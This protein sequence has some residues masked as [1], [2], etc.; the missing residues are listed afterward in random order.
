MSSI[1]VS[2]E[3]QVLV[4]GESVKFKLT[5]ARLHKLEHETQHRPLTNNTNYKYKDG[6]Q[7]CS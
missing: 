6:N 3:G 5:G 7:S 2:V 4:Y 1:K